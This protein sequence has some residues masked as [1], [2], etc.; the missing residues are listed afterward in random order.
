MRGDLR[1]FLCGI[2]VAVLAL[3]AR[4]GLS[5]ASSLLAGRLQITESKLD[6]L[7]TLF[8]DENSEALSLVAGVWGSRELETLSPCME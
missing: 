7:Q 4:Q 8:K 2:T 1:C 6:A 3:P 5:S